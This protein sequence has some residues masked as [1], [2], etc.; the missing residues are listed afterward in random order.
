MNDPIDRRKAISRL[1][2]AGAGAAGVAGLSRVVRG[3]P[4]ANAELAVD[5]LLNEPIGTIKPSIY[6]QFAEH[7]GGV[8]YD[9]IWV[10]P[11]RKWPIST[12]SARNSLTMS[13]S[14]GT[15][16]FAGRA[17]V[18]PTSITGA[19]ASARVHPGPAVRPVARGNRVQPVRHA[20][21]HAIL[22]ALRS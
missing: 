20:R 18:S 17:A 10:G 11:N 1:A 9:G 19:T 22:P 3:R 5:V 4:T 7:I 16:S 2:F 15:S 8:I 12:A 21:V 6:S 14:L 13:N